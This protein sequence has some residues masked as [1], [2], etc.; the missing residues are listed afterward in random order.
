[1]PLIDI[2]HFAPLAP[3]VSDGELAA[4]E[5]E[6]DD[7]DLPGLPDEDQ[8]HCTTCSY[9]SNHAMNRHCMQCWT[10]RPGWLA[11]LER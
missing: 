2:F 6:D 9:S 8:W 10:L 7:T 1:M 4:D 5:E 11:A 3:A